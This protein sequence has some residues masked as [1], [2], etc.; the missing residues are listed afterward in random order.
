LDHDI[1]SYRYRHKQAIETF[2]GVAHYIALMNPRP[3]VRIHTANVAAGLRMA[4]ILDLDYD[5]AIYDERNYELE[6]R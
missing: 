2:E 6:T 4:R 5:Y 3:V 1:A